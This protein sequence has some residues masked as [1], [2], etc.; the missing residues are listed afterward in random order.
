FSLGQASGS[1]GG[2]AY[3]Q[4]AD[5]ARAK[6]VAYYTQVVQAA[7]KSEQAAYAQHRLSRLKLSLDT[8]QRR[9]YCVYN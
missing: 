4:G 3:Q 5:E 9:F 2:P 8:N 6:A 1:E 7:P